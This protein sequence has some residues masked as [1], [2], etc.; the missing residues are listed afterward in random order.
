MQLPVI[1]LN[2][3]ALKYDSEELMYFSLLYLNSHRRKLITDSLELNA[4]ATLAKEIIDDMVEAVRT[5]TP[6]PPNI[7]DP[8]VFCYMF[9]SNNKKLR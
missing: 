5:P 6:P 4:R 2:G 1:Q 8:I 9:E 3:I 7:R